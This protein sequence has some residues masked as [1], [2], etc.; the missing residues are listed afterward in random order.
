MKTKIKAFASL[1]CAALLAVVPLAGCAQNEEEDDKPGETIRQPEEQPGEQEPVTPSVPSDGEEEAHPA[2]LSDGSYSLDL[3]VY[4]WTYL[5]PNSRYAD[6]AV[7]CYYIK[8]VVY[9]ANPTNPT[10]QCLNIYVPVEYLNEDGTINAT[11]ERNGYTAATAP[12]LYQNSCGSYYGIA[13]YAIIAGK[14]NGAAQGWYYRYLSQGYVIVFAGERGINT[15]AD[16]GTIVGAAPIGLSDLKAGL[17]YLRHN[18]NLIPGNTE[19]IISQGMSAGG[20]MSSLL[21]VS[22]NSHYFDDYLEEMGAVMDERDDVYADQAYCPIIDL[23]HAALAY[24][25]TYRCDKSGQFADTYTDFTTALSDLMAVK[26]AEYVNELSLKDADG[27]ALTLAA[28]GSQSGTLYDW[29]IEQYED[30][31]TYYVEEKNK[32]R[33]DSD[34][35]WLDY[36]VESCRAVLSATSEGTALESLIK[37]DY[38]SRKKGC[39]SFDDLAKTGDNKVF[40]VPNSKDGSDES[41]RHYTTDMPELIEK[42]KE[43][44]PTEY[45]EYYDAYYNDVTNAEVLEMIKWY[46][47]YRY[48]LDGQTTLA[49][50]FRINVGSEDSDTSPLVSGIFSLLLGQAGVDVDYNI[51]W[52]FGH[53]DADYPEDFLAWSENIDWTL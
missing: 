37:S 39:L 47:P 46:N 49:K 52:G 31:Y 10:L 13:P 14:D 15:I 11:G 18:S 26:Y 36:S 53:I 42:L 41:K 50:Y 51:V 38:L 9:C 22:G 6:V 34:Y 33:M 28:D 25:W 7:P 21:G 19:R 5:K 1:F 12:I 17:R 16:D 24:E 23:D 2:L 27:N 4:E 32:T 48:I 20:A 29:L 35:E 8:N 40:G 43:T 45:A 3:S 44:Y 30:S